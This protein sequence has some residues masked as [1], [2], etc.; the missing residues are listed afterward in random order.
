VS[1]DVIAAFE[2]SLLGDAESER[3]TTEEFEATLRDHLETPAIG[4]PLP[5]EGI[6]LPP[7]VDPPGSASDLTEAKT[8]VTPAG[9]GIASYGT[10]T[11][12]S[13]PEGDEL[14]SLY[15]ERHVAVVAASDVYEDPTAAFAAFDGEVSDH[16]GSQVLETGPSATAD[17]G[18]L[19]EGVHGPKEVHVLILEDR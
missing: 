6:S 5:F 12:D 7:E 16:R 3:T 9:A 1:T 8:G 17:M 2:D 13:R 14:V 15:V 19:V 10:V 4:V 11:V 18:S